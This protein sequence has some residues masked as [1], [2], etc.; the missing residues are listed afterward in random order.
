[1]VISSFFGNHS[2]FQVIRSKV[3]SDPKYNSS[4]SCAIDI[5]IKIIEDCAHAIESK[6]YGNHVGNFGLTGCFSF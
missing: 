5:E 1:M 4:K 3:S 6:Y 2:I